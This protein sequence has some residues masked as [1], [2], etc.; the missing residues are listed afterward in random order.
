MIV[1]SEIG[2]HSR[3]RQTHAEQPASE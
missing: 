2:K 1:H 3:L